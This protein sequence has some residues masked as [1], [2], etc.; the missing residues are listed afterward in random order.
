MYT[1]T[2]S[3]LYNLLWGWL[4]DKHGKNVLRTP[5]GRERYPDFDLYKAIGSDVKYAVPFRQIEAKPFES[6]HMETPPTEGVVY[7]LYI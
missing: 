2:V 4:V 5:E 6:F 1:E 7:D 3:P